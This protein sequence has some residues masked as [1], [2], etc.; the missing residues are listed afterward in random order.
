MVID[1]RLAE[2]LNMGGK[3]VEKRAFGRL[4]ISTIIIGNENVLILTI[5]VLNRCMIW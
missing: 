1:N 5:Y 4:D 2:G 3:R